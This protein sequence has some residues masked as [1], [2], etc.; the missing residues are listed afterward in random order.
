MNFY[1]LGKMIM[2][3][4]CKA[5]LIRI[6]S[7]IVTDLRSPMA[8]KY[9]ILAEF[10]PQIM[11]MVDDLSGSGYFNPRWS[12]YTGLD[13]APLSPDVWR[14]VVHPDD[15]PNVLREFEK[16][17]LERRDFRAK[18]RLLRKDG[19]YRWHI[20]RSHW[21]QKKGKRGFLHV[22]S[23]TDVHDEVETR[24]ILYELKQRTDSVIHS[25]PV[26]LW[27]VNTEGIFTYYDG[28]VAHL[29]GYSSEARIGKSI[30]QLDLDS[31]GISAKVKEALAGEVVISES[32]VNGICLENKF[33]PQRDADGFVTGV[34]GLSLDITLRKKEELERKRMAELFLR[35]SWGMAISDANGYF[36]QVNPAFGKMHGTDSLFWIG[37]HVREMYV[38]MTES[39]FNSHSSTINACG[40][41]NFESL[42][43]TADG[44]IF[45]VLVEA[46]NVSDENGAVSYRISNFIDLSE[47]KKAELERSRAALLAQSAFESSR[48][49]SEFL[50]NVSHE[51]RTP[52]NGIMG[53][54]SLL[55][56]T[57]LT[58]IQREYLEA[59]T[60]SSEALLSVV[61]DILDFSKIEAGKLEF[62][63]L[64]FD[65]CEIVSQTCLVMR[66]LAQKKGLGL[67]LNIDPEIGKDLEGDAGRIRQI[68]YNLIGNAVKF[69][70]AGAIEI[71]IKSIKKNALSEKIRFE[72]E[73]TGIG[74]SD[75]GIS[76]LFKAFSQADSS[77]SRKYGGSG[78]G[79][80][81]CKSLVE[82]HGGQIGVD[83]NPIQGLTFWFTLT[84]SVPTKVP[85]S[86]SVND[87]SSVDPLLS[88]NLHVLVADDNQIN[89]AIACATLKKMG[90][91]TT[92]AANGKEVLLAL[93][94]QAFDLVLMDCQ[95]PDM[96]GYEAT[97]WIRACDDWFASIPIVAMTANA[98]SGDRQKCLDSGMDDYI[99]K[100]FNAS[101]L[102]SMIVRW[103]TLVGRD[104]MTFRRQRPTG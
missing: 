68:L 74:L 73:D 84:L 63:F 80:S 66:N 101:T 5:S 53:M 75:Q 83:R 44:R 65:I 103:T 77:T 27:A 64:N 104:G 46:S 54:I 60:Y 55:H 50:A 28:K 11:W 36:I 41:L 30:F 18:Y 92:C 7:N 8:E 98:V 35:A 51:I 22:G 67:S 87:V 49:K 102:K 23:A 81:I 61:N 58:K 82:N 33:T 32:I 2:R 88:S 15:L 34:I 85:A 38:D 86:Q 19:E 100:P 6:I 25:A 76:K 42:H 9:Q 24:A 99:S 94:D 12:E 17:K 57:A 96:D 52:I 31:G 13:L 20:G 43:R 59:A 1:D 78:L 10:N 48:L 62:E 29:L 45:P 16:S 3:N 14:R 79:L 97:Q 47:L 90:V 40:R 93:H 69:T 71:R 56:D 70:P 89:Q 95:M 26:L 39:E 21:I 4:A 72:I 37:R 91:I